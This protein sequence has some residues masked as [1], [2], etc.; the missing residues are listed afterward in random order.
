MGTK[1]QNEYGNKY[2]TEQYKPSARKTPENSNESLWH[3][4]QMMMAWIHITTRSFVGYVWISKY[5]DVK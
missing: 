3:M 4:F 5:I 2:A 1:T